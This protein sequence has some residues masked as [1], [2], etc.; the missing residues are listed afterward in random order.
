MIFTKT[1]KNNNLKTSKV[2]QSGYREGIFWF[3][4]EYI[5]GLNAINHFSKCSTNDI[6]E[7]VLKLKNYLKNNIADAELIK[8]PIKKLK[9]RY[10]L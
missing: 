4:M 6:K 9:K 10:C 8:P 5:N 3:D 2:I 1:K 7:I